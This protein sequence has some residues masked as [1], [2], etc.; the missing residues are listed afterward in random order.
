MAPGGRHRRDIKGKSSE[1]DK[2]CNGDSSPTNGAD[3]DNAIA[4]DPAQLSPGALSAAEGT[5]ESLHSTEEA[6]CASPDGCLIGE[7]IDTDDPEDAVRVICSNADCTEGNFMHSVCFEQ[8]ENH[9]LNFLKNS[10]RA[11]NWNEKQRIQNLWSKRGYDITY[12]ACECPC[13]HGH[14][15]KDTDF[16]PSLDT[17]N[18][19]SSAAR[20]NN[21]R[22]RRRK[23]SKQLP[24]LGR[25]SPN[26]NGS[27]AG[28]CCGGSPGSCNPHCPFVAPRMRS[29]TM[30]LG[31]AAGLHPGGGS[32]KMSRSPPDSSLPHSYGGGGHWGKR[33]R[34]R[35]E[36]ASQNEYFIDAQV[37]TTGSIFMRRNSMTGFYRVLPKWKVNGFHIKMEDDCPQGNDDTRIFLLTT[38]GDHKMRKCPCML[39]EE[40]MQIY[41]RYPLVDGTFFLSPVNHSKMGLPVRHEGRDSFLMALCVSCL[42]TGSE[43]LSCLRCGQKGWFLGEKLMLGT[44]YTYDILSSSPCCPPACE[45]CRGCLPLPDPT[46]DQQRHFSAFSEPSNCPHCNKR[47]HHY[48]RR[49][50]SVKLEPIDN[51]G[52]LLNGLTTAQ[53]LMAC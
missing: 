52:Q 7:P 4:A 33:E 47:D 15:R 18:D 27:G 11:R 40:K 44:L 34:L 8:W 31:S 51:S 14:L 5:T 1:S 42:E 30:S 37:K 39:C 28:Q 12:R 50:D 43:R 25:P 46:L 53:P 13:G 36:G 49:K 24:V 23:N 48:V 35:S 32:N 6:N 19:E 9:I 20:L 41:D 16:V 26:A 45:F 38:L 17:K 21:K 22:E 2:Q 3:I 10:G 29:R